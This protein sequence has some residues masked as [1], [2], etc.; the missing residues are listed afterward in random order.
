MQ[1]N[2]KGKTK[3]FSGDSEKNLTREN[4]KGAYYGK[5]I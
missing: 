3:D 1:C 4:I 5:F 2:K